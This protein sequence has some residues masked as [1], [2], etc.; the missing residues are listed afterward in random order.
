MP[1]ESIKLEHKQKLIVVHAWC[2]SCDVSLEMDVV[3][4]QV[5]NKFTEEA[6]EW[7]GGE[8]NTSDGQRASE[9]ELQGRGSKLRD[10]PVGGVSVSALYE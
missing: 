9:V 6:I 3:M 2:Q 4:V 1:Y 8:T 10:C 5:K 7:V